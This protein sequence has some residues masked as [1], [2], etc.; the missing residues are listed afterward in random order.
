MKKIVFIIVFLFSFVINAQNTNVIDSLLNELPLAKDDTVR[1]RIYIQLHDKTFQSNPEKA[2]IYARKGLKIVT[3]MNWY[4][5]LSV[6][7]NDMGNNYLDQGKHKEA[8][9]HY[10][11]S[12]EFSKEILSL[13]CTTLQNTSIVITKKKI[14]R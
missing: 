5:G 11:K 8:L 3:K 1:A 10:L 4:K 7:Y 9:E 12:L 13:R 2:L 14:F 6:F